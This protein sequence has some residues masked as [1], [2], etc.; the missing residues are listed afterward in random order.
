MRFP[1]L[2]AH[3]RLV[4]L[5]VA[6]VLF[7]THAA[8]AAAQVTFQDIAR[9]PASGLSYRR[10]PSARD[11]L[12]DTLKARDRYL[13]EDIPFTPMKSR[14]APGVAIFDHDGDGDLDVYVTNGPNAPN[15]L[16]ENQVIDGGE[17]IFVDVA[18]AAGVAATAQDS[19]GVCTGDL[20]NDGDTD[21]LVLGTAEGNLLFRNEGDGTYA[22]I[23]AASGLEGDA[24]LHLAC[25][26]G[27]IDNDGLLD[28]A[29]A[30]AWSACIDAPD[31]L[32]GMTCGF[33]HQFPIEREPFAL[34]DHNQLYRNLGDGRFE[35][36][37]VSAGIE[38]TRGFTPPNPGEPT[39]TW[40]IALVDI[41]QDGDVDL[42]HADDQ[43]AV[44]LSFLGGVDRG[45]I[46]IWENDGTG[47]FVSRTE[48]SGTDVIGGWMGFAFAD[49]NCDRT[50]DM[51]VT[52]VGD[53]FSQEVGVPRGVSAS[54]WFLRRQDG[55]YADPG[56]GDLLAT[57]FGWGAAALDADNDGDQD[58]VYHGGMD[59][60]PRVDASNGGVLL[61][62]EGCSATFSDASTFT[63]G[64]ARRNG[65]GVAVGDLDNDG[66]TDI[67]SVSNLVLSEPLPL[68]D[69]P[70]D[71][72]SPFDDAVYSQTFL[73]TGEDGVWEFADV[74][75]AD[76]DLSVE[77]NDGNGNGWIKV[78][79]L[80]TRGITPA[81][82]VNR[83]G[84]GAVVTFRPR[85]GQPVTLPAQA[86]SS[87]AS[88]N[89]PL[90]GFGLGAAQT[91]IVDVLWPGGVRNRW[92]QVPANRTLI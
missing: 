31:D 35:D 92:Y 84:V 61:S 78:Q 55:T 52:N 91:G 80:G 50:L 1:Q 10:A 34:N 59:I 66:F 82:A 13:S 63:T 51:F 47:H 87:Y 79:L 23:S 65:Q 37:S 45:L 69:Y 22:D 83:D 49:Y 73:P 29:V 25:A 39:I 60:G 20:D 17:V 75:Y 48:A 21:L 71:Y 36:V 2:P 56:V 53:Y 40:A 58:I 76:G 16:F 7:T 88:S 70:I 54:R 24:R 62:N 11:A 27:D 64:H 33:E 89:S 72:G 6:T 77:L 30:N 68:T 8:V 19:S 18:A 28:I 9:D 46:Q 67:V 14:G 4:A 3:A 15:S 90:L 44:P 12:F 38:E 57:P 26:M 32:G 86:G 5:Y 42:V 85:D 41:D 74:E 81:G 43:A